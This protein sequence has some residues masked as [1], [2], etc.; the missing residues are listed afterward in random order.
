M[1]YL[2]QTGKDP[3]KPNNPSVINISTSRNNYAMTLRETVTER[4]YKPL[5]RLSYFEQPGKM[6]VKLS[7]GKAQKGSSIGSVYFI[8]KNYMIYGRGVIAVALCR[9]VPRPSYIL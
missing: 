5:N 1:L 3:A 9:I 2:S 8:R 7:K 4:V 6:A